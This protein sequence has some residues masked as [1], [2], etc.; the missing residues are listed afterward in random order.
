MK[1]LIITLIFLLTI[2]LVLSDTDFNQ[3]IS[4]DDKAQFDE[5][6]K[7]VLKIYH[8]VKYTSTI[9]AAIFLL[10]AGISYM[11]SGGEPFKR[12]RAKNIASYVILG[13][14]IIWATPLFI[15][16]LG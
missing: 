16:F 13:L 12:D 14:L 1:F 10:Y 6:L 2:P 15:E 8:L 5:M 7:P 3:P 4:N 9:I 11:M